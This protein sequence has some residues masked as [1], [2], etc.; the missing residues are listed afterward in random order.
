[1]NPKEFVLH[2]KNL[3]GSAP[4][5][6]FVEEGL[7]EKIPSL[8]AKKFPATHYIIITDDQVKKLY[9]MKLL[10]GLKKQGLRASL[11]SVPPIETSK[12]LET[13]FR[14]L[15]KMAE[16]NVKRDAVILALGGGV[17][18]DIAGFTAGIFLRGIRYIHIPTT[19]LSMVDSSIGGKTG[20][21]LKAGKNLVG[22]FNHPVAILDDP[23]LLKTLPGKEIR[24]GLGEI[25]KHAVIA[26]PQLFSILERLNLPFSS[27]K[28]DILNKIIIQNI[29]IKSKIVM[30]D[31]QESFE[32]V[33]QGKKA[34]RM[35]VNYGHTIGH[36][37]E[38]VMNYQI[39]HGEAV[40]IG[41]ALEN[42]IAVKKKL[43]SIKH[44]E[45]I[46]K[47]IKK[48]GLPSKLPN[49][50]S[51][52]ALDRAI[53]ADKKV[54]GGKLYFALPVKIGKAIVTSL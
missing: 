51:L 22:L 37:I 39:P 44:A 29:K 5:R 3:R 21:D 10:E 34:S 38:K 13:V 14:L 48:F 31:S 2:F 36:G 18:G 42:I 33:K 1:M 30:A 49:E 43:L 52:K 26:N 19:L 4:L 28:P 12:N 47:L 50:V 8:L 53:K 23:S 20:V 15:E 16:I 9:G 7:F 32:T 35:L 6:L 24:N 45:R 40:A 17:V 41:M 25:I 46:L 54:V 27:L 11:I